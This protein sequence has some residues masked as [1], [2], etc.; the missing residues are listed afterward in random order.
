LPSS[1]VLALLAG[2]FYIAGLCAIF[3]MTN[4]D[5]RWQLATA[6]NRAVRSGALLL[7]IAAVVALR[8]HERP[9]TVSSAPNFALHKSP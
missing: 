1:G 6:A 8:G 3:A 7:L 5:L 9:L 2:L 4:A